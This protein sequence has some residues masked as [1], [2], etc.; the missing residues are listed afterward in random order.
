VTDQLENSFGL[1]LLCFDA[2]DAANLGNKFRLPH[3]VPLIISLS[4]KESSQPLT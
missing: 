3:K 4:R 2:D 1:K